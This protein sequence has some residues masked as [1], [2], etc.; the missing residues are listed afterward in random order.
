MDRFIAASNNTVE[1]DQYYT[2]PDQCTA[3][4]CLKKIKVLKD[5]A[6]D[7]LS[8]AYLNGH[9]QQLERVGKEIIPFV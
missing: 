4:E 7:E 1:L 5:L 6:F 3:Q 9:Y 2:F 8:G